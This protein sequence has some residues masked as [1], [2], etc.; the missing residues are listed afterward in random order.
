MLYGG[1]T[2]TGNRKVDLCD[3]AGNHHLGV[4]PQSGEEH[5][6]L[7]LGGVLRFIENDERIVQCTAT[8]I[9]KRCDLDGAVIHRC[10]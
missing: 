2:R 4:E 7:F 5:L 3:I 10:V 6:H 8:H 1:K 9:G